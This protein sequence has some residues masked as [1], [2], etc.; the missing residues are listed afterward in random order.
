MGSSW[1]TWLFVPLGIYM[2]LPL[3][4]ESADALRPLYF[5]VQGLV[6]VR[7]SVAVF[8]HERSRGWLFYLCIL[9]GVPLVIAPVLSGYG[10]KFLL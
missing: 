7:W 5:L 4:S 10:P 6:L 3:G 8:L 9:L 1:P 2:A